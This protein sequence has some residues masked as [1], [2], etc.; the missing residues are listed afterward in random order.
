MIISQLKSVVSAIAKKLRSVPS[1][2][3]GQFSWAPP[4]WLPR[5]GGAAAGCVRKHRKLTGAI[6]LFAIVAGGGGWRT[7]DWYKHRPQPRKVTFRID[8]I[9]PIPVTRLDKTL[10]PQEL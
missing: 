1:V 2:L 8:P 10:W 4:P 3:F 5:V 6:L 7:W 9:D